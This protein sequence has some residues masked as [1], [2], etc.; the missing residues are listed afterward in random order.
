MTIIE[1]ARAVPVDLDVVFLTTRQRLKR[2]VSTLGYV[3]LGALLAVMVPVLHFALVP[4]LLLV[5]PI[6]AVFAFRARVRLDPGIRVPCPKCASKFSV[7]YEHYGWP[8]RLGCRRCFAVLR[9]RP[10]DPA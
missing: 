5:G 9:A 8:L 6:A 2:A 7:E 10:R 4:A 1:T 3:W